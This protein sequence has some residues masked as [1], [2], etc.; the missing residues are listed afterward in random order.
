V[1]IRKCGH[2]PAS[3]STGARPSRSDQRN[4]AFADFGAAYDAACPKAWP[5]PRRRGID[6]KAAAAGLFDLAAAL[7]AKLRLADL[8][9]RESDLDG[10]ADFGV[11]SPSQPE[12]AHPRRHPRAARGCVPWAE[13]K[14]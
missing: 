11:E 3:R 1:I 8:G 2:A 6:R 5:E 7:G 9:L 12:P 14:A 13:A 4:A 10:T